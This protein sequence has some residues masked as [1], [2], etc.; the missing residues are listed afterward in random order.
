MASCRPALLLLLAGCPPA[1]TEPPADKTEFA[2]VIGTHDGLDWAPLDGENAEM[3]LGFQGFLFIPFRL[4]AD[5]APTNISVE[6][7]L[8]IAG[9]DPISGEQP[10]VVFHCADGA[11]LTGD[12]LMFLTGS[13]LG[14]YLGKTGDLTIRAQDATR[15]CITTARV[16]LVDDECDPDMEDCE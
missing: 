14:R 6:L 10:T 5:D 8:Q 15:Y 11:C 7:N 2:C 4:S 16:T 9:M 3:T 1:I 13:T 12:V